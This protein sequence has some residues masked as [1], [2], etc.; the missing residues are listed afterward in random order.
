MSWRYSSRII[1]ELLIQLTQSNESDLREFFFFWQFANLLYAIMRNSVTWNRQICRFRRMRKIV[2]KTR[3]GNA[4]VRTRARPPAKSRWKRCRPPRSYRWRRPVPATSITILSWKTTMWNAS[5]VAWRSPTG[6]RA[7]PIAMSLN[8]SRITS[9]TS[10]SV[11][12]AW[13]RVR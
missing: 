5:P 9:A 3:W 13:R 8:A 10:W 6:C 12:S 2:Q 1:I 11:S 4:V 7:L